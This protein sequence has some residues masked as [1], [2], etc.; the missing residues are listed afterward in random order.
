M[1]TQRV[2]SVAAEVFPLIK[3]GGLGD[4]VGALPL[5]LEREGVSVQ[6]LVPGYPAVMARLEKAQRV[7]RFANLMGGPAYLLR[8]RAAGLDLFVIDA[9]HLYDRPGNPYLQASGAEWPDNAL[10]FAALAFVGAE[11]G[12]GLLRSYHPTVIQAH[13][14]HAALV[15][16]YLHYG[17]KKGPPVVL[18]IHNLAFQGRFP[19][20]FLGKIGLPQKAFAIDGVEYYGDIGFLKAGILF[21]DQVTTVSPAYAAEIATEEGGMGL[22]G[23][24]RS[25]GADLKGILNGIDIDVWD[26]SADPA[27]PAPFDI[28]SLER[29]ALNKLAL[30]TRFGLRRDPNTPLFGIVSRLTEQKGVDLLLDA[31]PELI[32]QDAQLVVVGSGDARFEQAFR[33]AA[34]TYTGQVGR[35]V[36]YDEELTHL[37]QAGA[38]AILAPSRFEPCGLT[39]LCAMRYGAIPVVA[40][41]GGLSDTIIDANPAA[42][43]Q[44]AG[45][46]V[47]FSPATRDMLEDAIR[48]TCQLYRDPAAWRQLQ[49]NAMAFDSSWRVSAAEYARLFARVAAV[50]A[51]SFASITQ[52]AANDQPA[53]PRRPVSSARTFAGYADDHGGPAGQAERS[54]DEPRRP[55][56]AARHSAV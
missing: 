43:A 25:R 38:D 23:L 28:E 56:S 1:K 48:R 32:A 22:G 42:I 49:R 27:I 37:V 15:P 16:A 29:R 7:H 6:T 26:P 5:A 55:H 34:A 20:R 13:D 45:T 4:V 30:Q 51:R 14:W 9:P 31:L 10:R 53:A 11:I 47:Q 36:G 2:L 52:S 24:L 19:A 12:A 46:G 44:G 8:G 40:R 33:Q 50:P 39:Q 21:A 35:F 18:S 41:T 17:R 54:V 3:T